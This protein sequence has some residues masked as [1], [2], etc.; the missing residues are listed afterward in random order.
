MCAKMSFNKSAYFVWVCM[1]KQKYETS[2]FLNKCYQNQLSVW[3]MQPTTEQK[4][5]NCMLSSDKKYFS[6]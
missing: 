3:L 4:K 5:E 6:H 2:K 1:V